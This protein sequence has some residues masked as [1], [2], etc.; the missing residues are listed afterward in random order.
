MPARTTQDLPGPVR[1][2]TFHGVELRLRG[3]EALGDC[4][5]CGKADKFS[6]LAETG[7]ARCVVCN[8]GS[9]SGGLNPL[10]FVR[11]LWETAAKSTREA[12]LQTL[13]DERGIGS[14]H[15][16][17]AWG[18]R[19]SHLTGEWMLPGYDPSGRI[20]Q[21]YRYTSGKTRLLMATPGLDQGVGLLMPAVQ[22]AS[23]ELYITEGPWDG[24]I[25]WETLRGH[26]IDGEKVLATS[27]VSGSI[28]ATAS[29]AAVPGAG[30]FAENWSSLGK[31]RP[32]V[33]LMFDSDHPGKRCMECKH[34]YL[35]T[36]HK[37]CPKCGK[38]P[39]GVTVQAGLQGMKRATT[40]LTS[41][42]GD[43]PQSLFYL[44]WGPAGFDPQRKHGWD[45]RD[46]L[47]QGS[48]TVGLQDLLGKIQPIPGDWVPGRSAG[49]VKAGHGR[50]DP[51]ECTSWGSLLHV[52]RKALKWTDGLDATY[53]VMLACTTSV[54]LA[55]D[56]TWI[57]VISNPSSG[58]STLCD[59]LSVSQHVRS[60]SII[61][62]FHSGYKGNGD[63][64]DNS[65]LHR[66]RNK[67]LITKDGDT[68]LQ[69]GNLSQILSEARDIY[70]RNSSVF[71]RN[72]INR[73]YNGYNMTWILCGTA[74]L[75]V[76]DD[77]ELG[78]RF[79]TVRIMEEVDEELEN[80]INRRKLNQYKEMLIGG[81]ALVNG[82]GADGPM[83]LKM[84]RMSGGYVDYLRSAVGDLVPEV[85]ARTP[86]DVLELCNSLGKLVAYSRCRRS[87]RQ[88]EEVH[89]ELSTR[90]V[91]Q[92]IRLGYCLGVVRNRPE[93]DKEVVKIL[94]KVAVDTARGRTLKLMDNLYR[95]GDEG[96]FPARLAIQC[97]ES[98]DECR[99]LLN[100]MEKI[101][102]A[103][104]FVTSPGA[105]QR[106]VTKWRL[107]PSVHSLYKEIM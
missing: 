86:D 93:I 77:S 99:D 13:A 69:V 12:E 33:V 87:K 54:M 57:K 80:E 103:E 26:R 23:N 1:P 11:L 52:C 91:L 100:F 51:M 65:L 102:S 79:L 24:M 18:V 19:K 9:K 88:S 90:L 71:Y 55:G 48:R 83:A 42:P 66:I 75:R 40:I 21:L 4:P 5:W 96:E 27:A 101:R 29:V 41:S 46:H 81:N 32:R 85:A 78:E 98:D 105:Y 50:P 17:T 76:L 92:F 63:E 95:A 62:G 53:S 3:D 61:T 38:E 37:A 97:H 36:E 64:E 43:S 7:V 84:K 70:D 30:A 60:E 28:A 6:V 10:T 20:I 44:N 58:K 22:K 72:K 47:S 67:T 34:T 74:S 2:Y 106:A 35:L 56:Q 89:R 15:T 94:R 31:D 82:V 104:R 107:T 59:A 8:T 45:L 68:L 14:H 25:W 16:L 73:Q 49:S 39:V